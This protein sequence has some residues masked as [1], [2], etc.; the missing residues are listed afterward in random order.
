MRSRRAA[1]LLG[2]IFST[3]AAAHANAQSAAGRASPDYPTKP[4]RMIVPFPPGG[5]VDSVAR[6]L[7]QRLSEILAQ[8]VAL[9]NRGGSGGIIAAG[10]AA[11]S[12]PDGYTL[13]FGGSAT[14]GITPHL[15]RRR[16]RFASD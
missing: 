5:G 16:S 13:L 15:Y 14:Q 7:G 3:I 12:N 8:T 1:L 11:T 2:A 6:I 9:D 10:I 4:V